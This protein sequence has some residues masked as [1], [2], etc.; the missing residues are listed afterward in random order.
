M[1][2]EYLYETHLHTAGVSACGVSSGTEMARY[3]KESGHDGFFVTDH[4]FNGNSAIDRSL[5]WEKRVR[6][7][8]AGYEEAKAE[9]DRIGIDVFFGIEWNFGGDEYLLYGVDKE[10]LLR[11]PDMLSWDYNRLFAE[12]NA[13]GGLMVQAHPFRDRDY[14][15]SIRLHPA[16]VHA[17]EAANSGNDREFDALAY[18]YA[19]HYGLP[20]TAGS[21]IHRNQEPKRGLRG[22]IL[23]E[24]IKSPFDY[25]RLVKANKQKLYVRAGDFETPRREWLSKKPITLTEADG[26]EK[27]AVLDFLFE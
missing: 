2:L 13:L 7:Y 11:N 14:I 22:V 18:A 8:C 15:H 26:V 27:P 20:M 25:A 10:W 4:F 12:I 24:R 3:M 21:D 5:P 19:S 6:L 17:V 23:P 16:H 9:G 1:K